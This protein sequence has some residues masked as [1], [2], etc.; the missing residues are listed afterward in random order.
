MATVPVHAIPSAGVQVVNPG[1]GKMLSKSQ[2]RKRRVMCAAVK[3]GKMATDAVNNMLGWLVPAPAPS[4]FPPQ[5]AALLRVRLGAI[6]YKLGVLLGH[7]GLHCN[8]DPA[9]WRALF[10]EMC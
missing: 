2:K 1:D 10:L 9:P 4:V 6:E 7:S 8:V 3:R 5:W